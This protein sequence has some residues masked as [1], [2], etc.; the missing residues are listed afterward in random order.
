MEGAYYQFDYGI[1]AHASSELYYDVS[2]YSQKYPYLT[3]YM[4][5]NQTSNKGNGVK[6]W[7]YTSNND[8]FAP[9]GAQNWEQKNIEEDKDRVIMPGQD[10]VYEK[11]DIRGA[12]YIR[13]QGYDNGGNGND[14][15]VYIN[16]MLISED[17][18]EDKNTFDVE[19]YNQK[20]REYKNKNLDDPN[21]EIL[22]LQ[23][24]FVSSVGNYALKRFIEE[25][26]QNSE[27]INWLIND[28]DN[29]R[30]YIMGGEPSGGYYNSLKELTR[31]LKE[32]KNDFND[33]TQISEAGKTLLTKKKLNWKTTK[34]DLY[35]RMV[36]TLSLTH[37]ARVGLWMQASEHNL[38]DS[39]TRY[40]IYKQ[41]YNNGQF[42][43][44]STVDMTPW[45]ETFNIEEMRWILGTA[46]DDEEIIWLNEYTQTK[47]D[48]NPNSVWGLLTPH[49]YM[50]YVWPNYSNPV[51]YAEE[52]KEY[53]NDLF[54]V[55]KTNEDGTKTTK[56]LFE[57]VPYRNRYTIYI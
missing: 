9:S 31:L 7:I 39:V 50:A 32:Y 14:H 37:S 30:Y 6:V 43:Q 57:Y 34:G 35:K 10:A 2:E 38:S 23:K 17:Y 26:P 27:T 36:I 16:P 42:K 47:I 46:I 5:I 25:D 18:Q 48:E 29:L 19:T 8:T 13:I 55:V 44:T 1:W 41:M 3:L 20:I 12:K 56:G 11:V 52:N 54:K 53:F 45:F 21:Y 4:G 28:V 51:Y 15:L 33:E 40:S 22:I 24:K 49:P